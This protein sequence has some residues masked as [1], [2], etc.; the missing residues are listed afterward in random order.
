[1]TPTLLEAFSVVSPSEQRLPIPLLL[2][3]LCQCTQLLKSIF[4]QRDTKLMNLV[5]VWNLR[6]SSNNML[7]T[8]DEDLMR[9]VKCVAMNDETSK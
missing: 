4:L 8:S 3:K 1:M 7:L 5:D 2:L 9:Y 6:M